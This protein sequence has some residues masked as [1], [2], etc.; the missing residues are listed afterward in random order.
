MKSEIITYSSWAQQWLEKKE[1]LVKEST[2]S[3]YSNIMVN[4]LVPKFGKLKL[5]SLSEEI[6][7]E[8]AFHLLRKGRLDG[9]GGMSM[10]TAKDIIVVLKNTLRDA[11][12]QRIL[13]QAELNIQFPNQQDQHKIQVLPK[14]AQRKLVQAIYLNLTPKSAGILI[15]LHTGLRIGE[16]CG[17]KWNDI[18]FEQKILKVQRTVQRV[19]CKAFDGSGKSKIVI[20]TP[21]TRS[22]KREI[23]LAGLLLPV[24]KKILPENLDTYFLSRTE[25]CLEVRTYRTFFEGFLSNNQIDKINFHALRHTFATR[26][27]EAGGDCKTVSELLGHSTV[28]MTLNL[29]VHPQIEHKRKCVELLIDML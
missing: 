29:Y 1:Q 4:H 26:C 23:P 3:A 25:K 2:F 17:L 15:A 6:I 21:K 12:R 16:I 14:E 24:L 7:Q 19:Y 18:D 27:I 5:D 8:Y 11:M 10:R 13:S 20:S 9:N 22:S 28:N